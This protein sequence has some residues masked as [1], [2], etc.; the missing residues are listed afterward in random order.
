M[1]SVKSV[2]P[3]SLYARSTTSLCSIVVRLC[4]AS[5]YLGLFV[6]AQ[7]QQTVI[8]AGGLSSPTV[9]IALTATF[10]TL[11][12]RH[13]DGSF[14][15]IGRVDGSDRYISMI[16]RLSSPE[17]KHLAPP[18]STMEE[19]WADLPRQGPRAIKR[20]LGLP[21]SSDVK[22][23]TEILEP[24]LDLYPSPEKVRTAVISYPPAVALYN[25]D[26]VD[27]AAYLNVRVQSGTHFGQPREMIAAYAGYG[28]GLCTDPSD[29]QGCLDELGGL[30]EVDV[31]HVEYTLKAM[32]LHVAAVRGAQS[33][34]DW[35]IHAVAH[36]D[37]GSDGRDDDGYEER[38]ERCLESLLADEYGGKWPESL[39]V[40]VTGNED[41]IGDGSVRDTIKHALELRGLTSVE[42]L[43][44]NPEY[45]AARGAAELA[46]R[47][48]EFYP[49]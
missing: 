47:G 44:D 7:G 40:I 15:D 10:G 18:Y 4:I 13:A 3:S 12:I 37:L 23:L 20:A 36:Y 27:A 8:M 38:V 17:Q 29:K 9:G 2:R 35:E 19:M 46:W 49:E 33:R 11:S 16:Q 21:A 5:F 26:I 28:R 24:L 30:H 39:V 6:S 25:E 22:I 32:L 42:I 45:V 43:L 41:N 48:R 34:A 31:L 1:K 14:E